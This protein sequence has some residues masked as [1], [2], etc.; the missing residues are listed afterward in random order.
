MTKKGYTIE[1]ATNG[2]VA[3]E[4]FCK[5]TYDICLIDVMMPLMDGFQL[6]HAVK[7]DSSLKHIPVILLTARSDENSRTLGLRCGADTYLVK[8]FDIDTLMAAM[9]KI[10]NPK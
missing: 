7:S 5:G 9:E 2:E 3:Y 10:I 1:H 6:C 4:M 8:P